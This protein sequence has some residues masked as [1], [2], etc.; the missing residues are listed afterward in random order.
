MK[1]RNRIS[2]SHLKEIFVFIRIHFFV[3]EFFFILFKEDSFE[4]SSCKRNIVDLNEIKLRTEL[5]NAQNSLAHI[6]IS[7]E[8]L[9]KT[10]RSSLT[11]QTC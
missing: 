1:D 2:F 10:F 4:K 7:Y 9:L 8:K 5:K 3:I 11:R 6:S